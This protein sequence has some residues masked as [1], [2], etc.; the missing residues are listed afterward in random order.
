MQR[1]K[2]WVDKKGIVRSIGSGSVAMQIADI[3]KVQEYLQ[4]QGESMCAVSHS[5][6]NGQWNKAMSDD[7]V[8]GLTD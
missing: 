4:K 8:V 2:I 7:G 6:L 5:I 3:K 1:L